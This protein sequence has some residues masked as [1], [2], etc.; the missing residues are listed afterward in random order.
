MKIHNV[1]QGSGEWEQVRIGKP[2]ASEFHRIITPKKLSISSQRFDYCYR[3]VAERLLNR[4]MES[5]HG[6]ETMERGKEN[7]PKAALA[8]QFEHSV[9]INKVG[10]I[11]TDDNSLG[12]SPDRLI[13]GTAA[14]VEIKCVAPQVIVK[15]MAEGMDS[16]Y[17]IQVQGQM[18]VGELE[19]VDRYAWNAEMPPITQRTYRDENI[20]K[21]MRPALDQ[22]CFE[23]DELHEKLRSW[24]YFQEYK[25]APTPAELELGKIFNAG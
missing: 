2:T 4:P 8:Y 3:L 23:I 14:A 18:L 16:E 17:L 24:G 25:K 22:F 12:A 5:L 11:T 10:F 9:E 20:M 21:I 6:V 19:Y 1:E 15:Y 7:E 13:A